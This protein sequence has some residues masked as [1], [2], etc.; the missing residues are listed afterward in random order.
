MPVNTASLMAIAPA[1]RRQLLEGVGRKLDLLLHR[2]TSDT[3]ATFAS[4]IADLREQEAAG[5]A[6]AGAAISGRGCALRLAGSGQ[7]WW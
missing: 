1:M 6:R 4:Q 5:P 2:Q 7:L 3:L